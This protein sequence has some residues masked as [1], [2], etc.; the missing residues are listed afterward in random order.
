MAIAAYMMMLARV[1]LSAR[2]ILRTWCI[3]EAARFVLPAVKIPQPIARYM[4]EG[5]GLNT[6]RKEQPTRH[7]PAREKLARIGSS[8]HNAAISY[9]DGAGLSNLQSRQT[10]RRFVKSAVFEPVDLFRTSMNLPL[11][12][13]GQSRAR[14]G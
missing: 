3:V 4:A 12:Q 5:G 2:Q 10:L 1:R 7:L 14:S 8:P 13:R 9:E 6:V 11:A